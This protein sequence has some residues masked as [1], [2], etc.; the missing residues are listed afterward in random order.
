MIDLQED[1]KVGRRYRHVVKHRV[2]VPL[3]TIRPGHTSADWIR[4]NVLNRTRYEG[5][6]NRQIAAQGSS[7]R[8]R[9][10]SLALGRHLDAGTDEGREVSWFDFETEARL[11]VVENVPGLLLSALVVSLL[12]GITVI[13]A[14]IN[15]G[16]ET[17]VFE[18]L[19]TGIGFVLR[20][21]VGGVV[22]GALGGWAPVVALGLGGALFLA[23]RRR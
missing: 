22:S 18:D 20:D 23:W 16:K 14:N 1:V 8:V 2:E 3:E 13:G 7:V 12:V 10:D 19:G 21:V 9:V 6:V 17:T 4:E 11:T 5:E 15:H